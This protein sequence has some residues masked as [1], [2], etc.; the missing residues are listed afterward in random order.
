MMR[1]VVLVVEDEPLVRLF[2]SDMIEEAGFEVLQAAD[3]TDA[4]ALRLRAKILL[5]LGFCLYDGTLL[6][7][8][9]EASLLE[10][11]LALLAP[12][13]PPADPDAELPSGE[14]LQRRLSSSNTIKVFQLNGT[15]SE[16]L[17]WVSVAWVK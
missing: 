3:A 13:P 12:L 1:P 4:L 17:T 7:Q 9:L 10:S 2:A 16:G 8:L 11:A 5:L 6:P 14:A 15:T